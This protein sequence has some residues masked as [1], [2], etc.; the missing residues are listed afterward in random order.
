MFPC[1]LTCYC[2][3]ARI[4]QLLKEVRWLMS[5]GWLKIGPIGKRV[6]I[7]KKSSF[8]LSSTDAG[9]HVLP[10]PPRPPT[11]FALTRFL[12]FS[13]LEHPNIISAPVS[14]YGTRVNYVYPTLD[15]GAAIHQ[16][17]RLAAFNLSG[18]GGGT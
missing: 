5:L 14:N 18:F 3:E 17:I 12:S 15:R 7:Q 2:K 9:T 1:E 8:F 6:R 4:E 13:R 16:G 11:P 10:P